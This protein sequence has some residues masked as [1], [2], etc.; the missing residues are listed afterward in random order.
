MQQSNEPEKE[1]TATK[2]EN[3]SEKILQIGSLGL[4]A[5][6]QKMFPLLPK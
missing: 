4:R 2:I 1:M 5:R 6:L 3:V